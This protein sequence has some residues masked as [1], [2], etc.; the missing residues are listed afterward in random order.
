MAATVSV[1]VVF[2]G[3][4]EV[5]VRERYH[6]KKLQKFGYMSKLGLPYLPSSLV[7][8]KIS[9]NKYSNVY[10]T[11]LSKMFGHFENKVCF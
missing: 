9:L 2:E 3:M 8:T 5:L 11:Y 10:P 1:M 4:S 7:W 6:K